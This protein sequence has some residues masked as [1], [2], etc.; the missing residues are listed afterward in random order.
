MSMK[1]SF[2]LLGSSFAA[3]AMLASVAQAQDNAPAPTP[4]VEIYTCAYRDGRDADDLRA[5]T[6]RFNAWADRNNMTAYTAFT[7]TP[8]LFSTDLEADVVWIGAWPNGT[9]MGVDEELYR[10]QGREIAAAFDAVADCDAHSLYAE[11]VVSQPASPPPQNGVA[12]FEDCSVH[13]GRTVEEALA[14]LGQWVEYTKANG[15]DDF[16]AVLFPLAGLAD[17]ADY[18]FKIVT[19]FTSLQTFGKGVDMY[20]GGG[21]LRG[22]ELFGRL[23]TCD[24]PRVYNLDRVRLAAGPP[25][26]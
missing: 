17:A 18:D 10:T 12:M 4:V 14:A 21:F 25:P 8:Y 7:A 11:V 2:T 13:D 3:A 24:S 1:Q 20:T 26:R 22:E 19:G 23:L 9:A 16:S 6:T 5:V 15:S